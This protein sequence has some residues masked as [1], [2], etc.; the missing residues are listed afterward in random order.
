MSATLG[1][2][3]LAL[4]AALERINGLTAHATWPGQIN[5]PVALIRP[6]GIE[7][8]QSFDSLSTFSMEVVLA[9]RNADLQSGQDD[10]DLYCDPDGPSSVQAVIE[11]DQTL[12]G[13]SEMVNVLRMHDYGVL[14]ISGTSYM[15]AI[16]D[17]EIWAS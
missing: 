3:R 6:T 1:Q 12:G 15:G 9:V 8:S 5:P 10:L 7:Y 2:V 17:V 4:Q 11:G 14:D 16:F 13:I